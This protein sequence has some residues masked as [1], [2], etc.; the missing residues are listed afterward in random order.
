MTEM[1]EFIPRTVDPRPSDFA[2]FSEMTE[3]IEL[4]PS[5]DPRPLEFVKFGE[6]T[7]MAELIPSVDPPYPKKKA[8]YTLINTFYRGP[9]YN[10]YKNKKKNPKK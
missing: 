9:P 10:A 3:M 5:V 6:M 4:I 1:T 2:E 8:K 7:E